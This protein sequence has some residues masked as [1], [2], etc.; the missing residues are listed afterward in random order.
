MWKQG[1]HSWPASLWS[2]QI[3]ELSGLFIVSTPIGHLEDITLRAL[4][5]LSAVDSIICEDTRVTRLLVSHYGISTP[6]YSYHAYNEKQKLNGILHLLRQ[7]K[8]IALVSDR[9]T[10]LISDP[11]FLLVRECYAQGI[12]VHAIPGASSVMVAAVLSE[13]SCTSFFFQGFLPERHRAQTLKFLA[14]LPVPTILFAS[15]HS[16]CK[17]VQE[18]SP[19]FGERKVCFLRELTKKFEERSVYSLSELST[20]A[21]TATHIGECILILQGQKKKRGE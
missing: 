10:P 2:E 16:L 8:K 14:S 19:F 11:G 17:I 9:G 21:A 6:C 20:W 18:L 4:R 1:T 15:P 12:P 13:F 5:T 7:G 3:Q